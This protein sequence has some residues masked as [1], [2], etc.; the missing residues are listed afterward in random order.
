MNGHIQE[1]KRKQEKCNKKQRLKMAELP[2]QRERPQLQSN[3]GNA[4]ILYA[5]NVIKVWHHYEYFFSYMQKSMDSGQGSSEIEP[6]TLFAPSNFP[7]TSQEQYIFYDFEIP[8]VSLSC[9]VVSL[10]FFDHSVSCP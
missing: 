9:S 10:T 2:I 1:K 6:E 4:R 5:G 3:N 7:V 8:Q